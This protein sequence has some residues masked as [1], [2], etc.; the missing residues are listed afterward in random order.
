MRKGRSVWTKIIRNGR[1]IEYLFNAES[2]NFNYQ[3]R[4]LLQKPVQLFQVYSFIQI[5]FISSALFRVMNFL[6]VVFI[7]Q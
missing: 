6:L 4:N 1:A 2:F 7:I 3:F 5:L